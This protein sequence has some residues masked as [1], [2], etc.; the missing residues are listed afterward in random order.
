MRNTEIV[1]QGSLI[2]EID[3]VFNDGQP[4]ILLPNTY[5]DT[6]PPQTQIHMYAQAHTNKTL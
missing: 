6:Q 2:H 4:D 3:N 1:S 5:V